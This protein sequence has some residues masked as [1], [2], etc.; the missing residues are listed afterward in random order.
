MTVAP[1]RMQISYS[2][3]KSQF[4]DP[5]PI[6]ADIAAL[7]R[8]GD[9][10]LGRAVTE[11]E[12][13]VKAF[14][15]LPYAIGVS[16]GTEALSLPLR[17][18]GIGHGD[19][20]ITAANSF[21]A[22]AGAIAMVGA[23]PVLV[24]NLEDFT[25]DPVAI[26]RAVTK[27]TKAIIPVHLTGTLA[28]MSRV[29][30]VANTHNLHIVEDAAQAMGA[31]IYSEHAGTLGDAAGISLHPLK[32]LNV[33]GDGGVIVTRS[34]TM[35]K[36]LRLLRNHGLAN[37]DDAV[38][39]GNNGRLSSIQAVVANHVIERLPDAIV[40]RR[41]IAATLDRELADLA[42]RVMTPMRRKGSRPVHQTYILR[43][44][45]RDELKSFLLDRGVDVKV[46][47]PVPIHLQ[48]IGRS[49]GYKEGDCPVAER[50]AR[51]ILTLP[52]N[53]WITDDEVAY[54]SA[55]IHEFYG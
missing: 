43:C 12:D 31:T 22:S 7:A 1:A 54:M 19:E 37:R 47:Y 13:R 15:G 2:P 41:E 50:H 55:A 24:D 9:F 21:V 46:H 32:M 42:P 17:A 36:K 11:F 29:R 10:T 16:S 35:D 49:L 40:R 48:T 45:R 18:L 30:F 23:T 20:V 14:T 28:D 25:I 6:L 34:K 27:R 33:W 53:E 39:W 5:E 51:T 38:L 8:S 26:E 52:C 44:D 3:L 4:A